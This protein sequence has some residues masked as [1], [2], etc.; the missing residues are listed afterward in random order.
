M[1]KNTA[2]DI[3]KRIYDFV[4]RVLKLVKQIPNTPENK[5]I[6]YQ[7][8]KSATS[9]GANDREA[10]GVTTTKDFI[11]KYSIVRKE[12]KETDYWLNI[13]ADTN[14]ELKLRMNDLI[15]EGVEII[16]IVNAII[17]NTKKNNKNKQ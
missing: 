1:T 13:I 3:H 14:P 9:I 11:N 6:I 5:V 4:I 16:K 17:Y 15:N 7:I 2:Q 12:A 8:T 10:D